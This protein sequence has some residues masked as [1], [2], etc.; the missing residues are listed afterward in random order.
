MRSEGGPKAKLGSPHCFLL[1]FH[2]LTHIEFL[3]NHYM[4]DFE[5]PQNFTLSPD[6]S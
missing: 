2:L 4:L 1:Y 6:L 3:L 5:I